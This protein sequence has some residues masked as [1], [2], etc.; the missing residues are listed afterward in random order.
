[1]L[2]KVVMMKAMLWLLTW[3]VSVWLLDTSGRWG[4]LA[5]SLGGESLT[6]GLATG[7]LAYEVG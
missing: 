2:E 1:M 4:G 7:G 3:L 5:G 6:W